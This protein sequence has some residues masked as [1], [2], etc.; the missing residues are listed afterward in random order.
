MPAHPVSRLVRFT[1][2][3]GTNVIFDHL[4]YRRP[5]VHPV[6]MIEAV[7]LV[8]CH[9]FNLA[10]QTRQRV[11][12]DV[13]SS[14]TW[15]SWALILRAPVAVCGAARVRRLASMRSPAAG[16]AT[17][18]PT[19]RDSSR[20]IRAAIAFGD[21]C[22]RRCSRR[23]DRVDDRRFRVRLVDDRSGPSHHTGGGA[24]L[25]PRA[26]ALAVLRH[27]VPRSRADPPIA[28]FAR[29][30]LIRAHAIG[31]TIGFAKTA[32]R[33]RSPTIPCPSARPPPGTS[34]PRRRGVQ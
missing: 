28:Q 30:A 21:A 25:N 15:P 14:V 19:R 31:A 6:R 8:A 24:I 5:T 4:G 33:S 13:T 2:A 32:P 9:V 26:T 27:P 1:L 22:D 23:R 34:G 11:T 3:V 29:T 17:R 18:A 12:L 10:E 7:E 20:A 16:K